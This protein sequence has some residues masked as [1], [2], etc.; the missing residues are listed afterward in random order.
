MNK[1]TPFY[2][3]FLLILLFSLTSCVSGCT[4][5]KLSQHNKEIYP[6]HSFVQ[7]RQFVKL[8]GCGLDPNTK[9]ENNYS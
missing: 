5:I 1:K 9:K 3:K 4:T 8:E 6:R 2:L 7:V